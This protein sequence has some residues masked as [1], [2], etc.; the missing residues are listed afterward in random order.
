[1]NQMLGEHRGNNL[2]HLERRIKGEMSHCFKGNNEQWH[3]GLPANLIG[4]VEGNQAVLNLQHRVPKLTWKL[5]GT[6]NYLPM[7]T[8]LFFMRGP[9]K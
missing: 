7:E 2:F 8:M 6:P 3:R 1:M 4:G 9:S 5:I